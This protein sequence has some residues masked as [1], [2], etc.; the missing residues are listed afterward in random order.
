[1]EVEDR[2]V[3]CRSC[4]EPFARFRTFVREEKNTR[5][6]RAAFLSSWAWAQVRLRFSFMAMKK[7]TASVSLRPLLR[8]AQCSWRPSSHAGEDN[9]LL[10]LL[11]HPIGRSVPL[12]LL[13]TADFR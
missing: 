13:R 11:L 12:S 7:S 3:D 2:R 5:S 6:F 10:L 1:M 4:R 8:S 9:A